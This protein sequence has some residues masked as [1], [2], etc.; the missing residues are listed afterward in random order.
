VADLLPGS[1]TE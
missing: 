1:Q